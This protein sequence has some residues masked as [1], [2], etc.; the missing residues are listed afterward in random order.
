MKF[1]KPAF[2]WAGQNRY[3]ELINFKMAFKN[4]L[5]TKA[6]ELS[7]EDK[8]PGIKNCVGQEDL[9]LI[10]TFTHEEKEKS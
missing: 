5:E 10:Q 1:V 6:Y 3:V 9:Q 2:N 4:I 7:E 8:V